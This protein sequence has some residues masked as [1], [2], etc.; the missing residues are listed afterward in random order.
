MMSAV[1]L[2]L[3]ILRYLSSL[4]CVSLT[5]LTAPATR[6][7]HAME[8]HGPDLAHGTYHRGRGFRLCPSPLVPAQPTTDKTLRVH[9]HGNGWS[10]YKYTD[11]LPVFRSI[12][13]SMSS[14]ASVSTHTRPRRSLRR[15]EP[16]FATYAPNLGGHATWQA[17]E[18]RCHVHLKRRLGIDRDPSREGG[19]L[20]GIKRLAPSG[21]AAPPHPAVCGEG[22]GEGEEAEH[23]DG[24]DSAV[25][26][27]LARG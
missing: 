18:R 15:S 27:G 9:C 3:F 8:V 10:M 26:P 16:V 17:R 19:A 1:L 24:D 7:D 11:W 13:M 21:R 23:D 20:H 12:G 4:A 6:P 22:E 5:R 2:Y 14:R 25:R